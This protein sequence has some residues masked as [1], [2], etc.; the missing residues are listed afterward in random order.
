MMNPNQ[1]QLKVVK[2]ETDTFYKIAFEGGG[3][4]PAELQGSF[5]NQAVADRTLMLYKAKLAARKPEEKPDSE[6]DI[7]ELLNTKRPPGRPSNAS[8]R[9]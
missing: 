6:K 8:K 7:I 1:K 5:T 9:Q 3:E 4:V 2:R